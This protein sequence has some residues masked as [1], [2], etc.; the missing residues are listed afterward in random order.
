M[1]AKKQTKILVID[2]SESFLDVMALKLMAHQFE[3]DTASDGEE[4]LNKARSIHPDLILLDVMLPKLNGLKICQ[5]LKY[6]EKFMDIPIILI[7]S[8]NQNN[9]ED[10]LADSGANMFIQKPDGTDPHYWKTLIEAIAKLLAESKVHA[11]EHAKE[12]A[13]KAK[14]VAEPAS[15]E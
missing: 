13:K 3:V 5:I 11:K 9:N 1:S 10:V 7:S 4:G 6:D 14:P 2:D 12:I 8:R 15:E